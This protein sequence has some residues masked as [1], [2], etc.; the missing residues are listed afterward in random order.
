M[1]FIFVINFSWS[2]EPCCLFLA[3]KLKKLIS[4]F[5]LFIFI[6]LND[7]SHKLS[8]SPL[9]QPTP[10]LILEIRGRMQPISSFRVCFILYCQKVQ[11]ISAKI[12]KSTFYHF[13]TSQ[14][15]STRKFYSSYIWIKVVFRLSN[16][17][18][19]LFSMTY[20][21][22][23]KIGINKNPKP[24]GSIMAYKVQHYRI[25]WNHELFWT[26]LKF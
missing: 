5:E 17:Y 16:K 20:R 23:L 10:S 9:F 2:W 13:R 12:F 11:F 6:C 19:H 14:R 4:C 7:G 25:Y 26:E 18:Y 8:I 24:E 21:G 3:K 1:Q 22:F 15:R